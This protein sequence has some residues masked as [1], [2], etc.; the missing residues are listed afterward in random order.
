[1]FGTHAF[2]CSRDGLFFGDSLERACLFFSAKAIAEDGRTNQKVALSTTI[3]ANAKASR[4]T[5]VI[6]RMVILLLWDVRRE[7]L[8][9][10][11]QHCG[12]FR[13]RRR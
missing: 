13:Y 2:T 10:T 7:R 8:N 1:M 3:A 12:N 5:I 9:M 4:M 6:V 11:A